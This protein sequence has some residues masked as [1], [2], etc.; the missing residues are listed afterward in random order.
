[1]TLEL[2]QREFA[3]KKARVSQAPVKAQNTKHKAQDS[4]II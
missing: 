4:E 1:M 3:F 2:K